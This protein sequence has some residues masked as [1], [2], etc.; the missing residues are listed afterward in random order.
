MVPRIH[1]LAARLHMSP[2]TLQKAFVSVTGLGPQ[3]YFRHCALNRARHA[4]LQANPVEDKVTAI[5]VGLGF[6][7]IGRFSVRYR[8]LFGESPSQTLQ[9]SPRCM[10]AIPG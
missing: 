5:A 8:E 7:E 9:R 3:A 2:R 6:S 10:V 1:V 4:L